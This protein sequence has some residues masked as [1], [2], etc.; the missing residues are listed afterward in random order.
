MSA[1]VSTIFSFLRDVGLDLDC[2][3]LYSLWAII[4]GIAFVRMMSLV[5]SWVPL[6]LMVPVVKGLNQNGRDHPFIG[7]RIGAITD[8][9]LMV[10]I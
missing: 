1:V 8:P 6:M 7:L 10:G 5:V 3:P 9:A 4:E 2:G